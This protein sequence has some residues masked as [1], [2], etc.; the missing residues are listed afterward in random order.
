M[1]AVEEE[2]L[3][4]L[5]HDSSFPVNA[6]RY[7]LRR[8]RITLADVDAIVFYENPE[9]R[10]ARLAWMANHPSAP[11]STRRQIL[12]SLDP[13][14][15]LH[16]V[17]EVLGYDG[18]V[19]WRNHH[20]SH[21]ASAFFFSGFADAALLVV[22]GVGE[23][24]TTSY[25]YAN[26][27]GLNLF[28]EVRFPHSLGL[29][30]SALT[31]FLGF[32]VNDGEYKVMGLAPY[33]NPTY[34]NKLEELVSFGDGGAFTVDQS[35]F[36]F[37][38]A[39]S[40]FTD[41]LELLLGHPPRTEEDPLAQFHCDLARS[42]QVLLEESL[43]RCASFLAR[44]TSSARLCMAGG[45]ALN[46]AANGRLQREGLFEDLF[47][48]PA[49][50]DA[51]GA[52]G[53]ASLLYREK[54]GRNLH[55]DRGFC[56]YL[57][58]EFSDSEV[59]DFLDGT[60]LQFRDFE[61]RPEEMI[62]ETSERLASG[63]ILG[64]FQGAAEFGPRALGSRSILADP[65]GD[66]TRDRVNREL[67]G[68]E[69]FRP[70]APAVLESAAHKFFDIDRPSPFM[71]VTYSRGVDG[72]LPAVTH[73]DGSARVQTVT[74]EQNPRFAGLLKE[75]GDLTG[76]PVLLNTSLNRRGEPT[77][78]SLE[79]AIATFAQ[80]GLDGIVVNS[81]MVLRTDVNQQWLETVRSKS[82]PSGPAVSAKV[83]A[84]F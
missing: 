34:L 61:G 26:E 81:F 66:T 21:A 29:V 83:Y 38:S 53:A 15:Y 37:F 43:L 44:S 58:P 18:D 52:V 16:P 63:A 47:V 76:C 25:G 84:M 35:C 2:K 42:A 73:V 12:Q 9:E 33:G 65:R 72:D 68:R 57:G 71:L 49:A 36:D 79:D 54:I 1:A 3:T 70:F 59:R 11:D 8:G 20:E 30:Y 39:T 32:E 28:E 77:A 13:D 80:S 41:R 10:T 6:I 82:S 4:R 22:D 69:G 67:K 74:F 14:Y 24:A 17:R 31:A 48:F 5:K 56:P 40:M 23:W 46:C 27:D 7:C 51:G 75:F 62:R 45:V 64:W 78:C 50:G 55:L 60:G 19:Y